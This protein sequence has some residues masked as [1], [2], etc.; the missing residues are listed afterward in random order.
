MGVA[1]ETNQFVLSPSP[2]SYAMFLPPDMA[3]VKVFRQELRRTLTENF[4]PVANIM[5]IELA[6]DEALTNSVA[7]NVCS[8]SDETIICRWRIEGSKFTLY[9]L[10]YG[11]GLRNENPV[12]DPDPELIKTN[13]SLCLSTF[14]E[15]IKNHQI[16][17]PAALPYNGNDQKHKNMGK[18]LKIISAMMDSV[19]VLFHGEGMVGEAP[20]GFKVMG[21]ILALEY[22]RAKHQ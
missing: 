7:A 22:D 20:Q 21:S 14:I 8:C 2:G 12:E 11:S 1:S 19:K 6:A 16:R 10:D 3:S 13:S 15:N 4:F 9:V 5:Q 18:G 17:K